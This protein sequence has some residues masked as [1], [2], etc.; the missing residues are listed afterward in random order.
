MRV[1]LGGKLDN[2]RTPP[3]TSLKA[4]AAA[5]LLV[6]FSAPAFADAVTYRGTIGKIDV[7]VELSGE[8]EKPDGEIYGRYFY[9]RKGIDIP[10]QPIE[11]SAG[12]LVVRE[13]K[14]CTVDTCVM[15]ENNTVPEPPL[16]A[17]WELVTKDGETLTGTWSEGGKPLPVELNRVGSR[18]VSLS[19]GSLTGPQALADA[20]ISSGWNGIPLDLANAPYDTMKFSM[21]PL[22]E[23]A[24]TDWSGS[25]F[26]YVT[27][28]RTKFAYPRIVALAD[29]GDIE[30]TNMYLQNRHWGMEAEALDCSAKQYAG[31]G[32]N[33]F[34]ADSVGGLGDYDYETVEVAYL[35]PTVMSW[36]ESGS[37]WCGGA[38]PYNHHEFFNLDVATGT[39]LDLS[40]IFRG[41]IAREYGGSDPVDLDTARAN[42]TAYEWGPN[43]SLVEFVKAH[44]VK[45]D[46]EA[47]EADCGIDELI[48]SNLKISFKDGERVLFT[49]GGLPNVI[50]ACG[51]EDLYETDIKTM[52]DLL[53]LTD[54]AR[55]YFPSLRG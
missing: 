44:R 6:A 35:S 37:I 54:E 8:V 52:W 7:V 28:P 42:P 10:L 53:F 36:T 46:D 27:D 40:R 30:P 22:E 48:T 11:H 20:A 4:L 3:M 1:A 2:S 25:Q 47:F 29:G 38:H 41:W 13:E 18:I 15:D 24:A 43:D 31:M 23:S 51:S 26:R 49:L 34:I 9:P 12:H 16:G 21:V 19:D 5:T 32:W 33:E 45:V 50:V 17:T 39:P 55:D 14:P